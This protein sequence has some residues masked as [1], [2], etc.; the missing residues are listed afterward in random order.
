[1]T[2]DD[3]FEALRRPMSEDEQAFGRNTWVYCNQHLR[4]HKTGWCTVGNRNKIKLDAKDGHE[5]VAEC[6]SRGFELYQG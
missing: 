4:A 2:E 3:T 6:K 1:M 5:A